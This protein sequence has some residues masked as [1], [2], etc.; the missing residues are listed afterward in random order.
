MEEI[1]KKNKSARVGKVLFGE[2][3]ESGKGTGQVMMKEILKVAF[4]ELR[5]NRVEADCQHIF[6]SILK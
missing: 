2:K 3:N 1:Y 4:N 5:L 6:G